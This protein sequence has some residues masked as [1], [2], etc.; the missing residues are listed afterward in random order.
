MIREVSRTTRFAGAVLVLLGAMCA[1]PAA[2]QGTIADEL[3]TK[4]DAAV[5][6]VL[7]KT[8]APSASIALVA[9][10]RIVYTHAYGLANLESKTPATPGMRYS[11]GSVS[12]QFTSSAILLLAEEGKL[13]LDD[14]VA[15]W[16]PDLTRAGE[17][18]IRQ[19]LSMTS[20]YQDYWPQDYVMPPM[21]KPV[22]AQA[23]LDEWARKPLDFE[24]GSRWQYSNT[25]YVIAG[26]IVEKASGIPLLE[27]LSKRI[28]GPLA[29][30]TVSDIDSA[31]LGSNDP[32]RYLRFALGPPRLAPKEGK[33]WLFAAGELAM[34]ADDLARWDV[35]MIDRTVL[36]PA[37]YREMQTDMRLTNGAG[38]R[39]GLGV[40]VQMTGGRR[41][42]AHG[43][44]VSGFTAENQVYPDDR[45][46]VVVLVNL[47]A[48]NASGQIATRLSG[49]L[50][51]SMHT[52]GSA[53]LERA[54][55]VFT[56]LQRGQIDRSLFTVNA[57]AYF[58]DAA[59]KDFAASLGPLGAPVEF[60]EQSRSLRGGMTFVSYRIRGSQA[61][62][63]ATTFVTPD[64]KLEQFQVAP[65]E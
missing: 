10:G 46:A 12:K 60:A 1:R 20:G 42:I 21:L 14:R 26:L 56:G 13:S 34:T 39:Y 40:Q 35:S 23:I 16:L 51:E 65:Q 55:S 9:E 59:L 8:G 29:M 37:S 33:G 36:H 64:G 19:I 27:F 17:V 50:F 44:E 24:P 62:V 47:D 58:D 25:N 54:R 3:R 11:I 6:D 31:P 61:T 45:A 15:R 28:F 43:G 18:T 63:V 22:T 32:A 7:T 49:L 38:T 41:L 52:A 30:K 5:T 2:G 53:M 48:S 4:I 57:N